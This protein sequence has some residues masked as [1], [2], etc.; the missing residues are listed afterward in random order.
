M[1]KTQDDLKAAFAGESQANRRYLAF[2][3][4][5]EAEGKPNLAK[6]FRAAAEGETVHAL[7]HL[8]VLGEVKTAVDNLQAAIAGETYEFETMYPGFIADAQAEKNK[9]AE[10]S[11]SNAN[12]VEKIHQGKYSEAL[13]QVENGDDIDDQEYHVCSICGNLFSGAVPDICPICKVSKQKFYL[14]S[15]SNKP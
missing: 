6:L 4:A 15:Y 5:A 11:F 12:S 7:N 1:G 13:K 2:A 9:G 8:R 3:K 10:L 14:V